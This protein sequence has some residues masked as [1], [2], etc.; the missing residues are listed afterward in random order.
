MKKVN[1]YKRINKKVLE[2]ILTEGIDR[3]RKFILDLHYKYDDNYSCDKTE[4][5]GQLSNDKMKFMIDDMK[6]FSFIKISV[7]GSQIKFIYHSNEWIE[8]TEVSI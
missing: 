4:R 1:E 5:G 8:F 3:K 6:K 7:D 2:K